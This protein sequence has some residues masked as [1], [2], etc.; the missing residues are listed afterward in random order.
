MQNCEKLS[1]EE[2]RVAAKIWCLSGNLELQ[3]VFTPCNALAVVD[4]NS[5]K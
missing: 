2:L 1:G 5:S 4:G 3:N